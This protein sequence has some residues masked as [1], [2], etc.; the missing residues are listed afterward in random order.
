MWK[1]F[2]W[3]SS[4]KAV[5]DNLKRTWLCC[6]G[7]NRTWV[8]SALVI[9]RRGRRAN[10]SNPW[11]QNYAHAVDGCWHTPYW[12]PHPTEAYSPDHVA[13]HVLL[14]FTNTW[15]MARLCTYDHISDAYQSG[16]FIL[17]FF[18]PQLGKVL[19][20]N[21]W[22]KTGKLCERNHKRIYCWPEV[23]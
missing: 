4:L 1:N 19:W 18:S 2:V 14:H 5:C 8:T 11:Q 15:D 13:R 9:T 20:S 22:Q 12:S 3:M 16:R 23:H 7:K 10:P 17:C 21:I 6:Q